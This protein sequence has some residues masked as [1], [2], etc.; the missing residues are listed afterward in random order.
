M[1]AA[2]RGHREH[3]IVSRGVFFQLERHHRHRLTDRRG[4]R[5][6]GQHNTIEQI[7]ARKNAD[8]LAVFTGNHQRTNVGFRHD[9]E[10]SAQWGFR[11]DAKR[12]A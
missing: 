10:S 2:F 5:Q 12:R 6:F 1:A 9:F 3:R 8:R 11:R 7:A 4:E